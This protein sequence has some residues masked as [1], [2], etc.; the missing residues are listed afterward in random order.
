MPNEAVE[1]LLAVLRLLEALGSEGSAEVCC[2]LAQVRVVEAEHWYQKALRADPD[3]V[4]ALLG[5]ADC[6]R[7]A[8][9]HAEAARLF[10]AA[11]EQRP[12]AL[13]QLFHLGEALVLSGS[14]GEGRQILQL[15]S[16]GADALLLARAAATTALSHVLEQQHEFAL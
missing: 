12:L 8:D 10:Q 6:H 4:P 14:A 7:K 3:C 2:R 11:H 13:K 5:A 9:R 15:V 1:L 16:E